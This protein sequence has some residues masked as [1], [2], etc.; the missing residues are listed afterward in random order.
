M[1][2]LG[3]QGL[4]FLLTFG[5]FTQPDSHESFFLLWPKHWWL[6]GGRFFHG[7]MRMARKVNYEYYGYSYCR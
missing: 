2:I 7:H 4:D 1:K 6:T 5:E 3:F